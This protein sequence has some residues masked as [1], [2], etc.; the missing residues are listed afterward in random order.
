VYLMA[1]PTQLLAAGT[2]NSI[3]AA[4]VGSNENEGGFFGCRRYP[5]A[6]PALMDSFIVGFFGPTLA[7]LVEAQYPYPGPYYSPTATLNAI[8]SDMPYRCGTKYLADQLIQNN[9]PTYMYSFN[10]L[11]GL[12][13]NPCYGAAHGFELPFLFPNLMPYYVAAFGGQDFSALQ[14]GLSNYMLTTWATFIATGS[15][16]ERG[17]AEWP[18]YNSNAPYVILDTVINPV[19]QGTNFGSGNCAFWQAHPCQPDLPSFTCQFNQSTNVGDGGDGGDGDGDG[20]SNGAIAGI[21]IG[22]TIGAFIV[23][24]SLVVI[25]VLILLRGRMVPSKDKA[26]TLMK[27]ES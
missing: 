3:S 7:P 6:T 25:G 5:G 20:L 4:I 24:L 10:D 1:Q 14:S 26:Y 8:F 23:F 19:Q 12:S 13:S 18:H 17:D 2:M 16:N 22:S 15:P 21:V 11:T 9:V 27:E